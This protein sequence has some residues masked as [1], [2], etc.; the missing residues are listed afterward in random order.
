MTLSR[1]SIAQAAD[2]HVRE[3]RQG[4]RSRSSYFRLRCDS[5]G[6]LVDRG[7]EVGSPCPFYAARGGKCRGH[8][9]SNPEYREP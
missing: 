5:C 6:Q 2:E 4:K 1:Q 7:L 8:L 9:T 3:L